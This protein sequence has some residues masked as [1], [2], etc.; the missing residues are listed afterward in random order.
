MQTLPIAIS[1]TRGKQAILDNKV[2]LYR[3]PAKKILRFF[4]ETKVHL[5]R[6]LSVANN[7]AN[8]NIQY[9]IVLQGTVQNKWVFDFSQNSNEQKRPSCRIYYEILKTKQRIFGNVTPICSFNNF[10][11]LS[12]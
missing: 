1:R 8:L 11:V 12:F 10:H 6:I 4:L 5:F 7:F 9:Y 3:G 2:Q